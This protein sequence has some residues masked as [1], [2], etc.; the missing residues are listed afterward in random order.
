MYQWT[1]KAPTVSSL[2]IPGRLEAGSLLPYGGKTPQKRLDGE[3]KIPKPVTT[4]TS[5]PKNRPQ[6]F[7][8]S[9]PEN[10][11]FL[12]NGTESDQKKIAEL[13]QKLTKCDTVKETLILIRSFLNEH[14]MQSSESSTNSGAAMSSS[15]LNGSDLTIF[16]KHDEQRLLNILEKQKQKSN[17]LLP[18]ISSSTSRTSIRTPPKSRTTPST[19]TRL[20]DRS[21]GRIRRNLSS[22]SVSSSSS[23]QSSKEINNGCKRCVQLAA[24][25]AKNT[26]PTAKRFV[27]KATVMDV[28]PIEF[29]KA[30]EMKNVEIQTDVFEE[31]KKAE[32]TEEKQENAIAPPPPPMPPPPPLPNNNAPKPPPPPGDYY[33]IF[34]SYF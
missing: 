24:T 13:K 22:D 25:I 9:T 34:I 29:P 30:L 26:S 4:F 32:G 10:S 18:K 17:E 31:E 1:H 20:T 3:S 33:L 11:S 23:P 21:T 12:L 27:D 16:N 15:L 7:Q 5:T 28:E 8:I 6:T 19:P 14:A 2:N